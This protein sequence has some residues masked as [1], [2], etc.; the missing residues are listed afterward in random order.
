[1]LVFF[2]LINSDGIIMFFMHSRFDV[3]DNLKE[4]FLSKCS[5]S[6]TFSLNS[7]LKTIFLR[8]YILFVT[9]FIVLLVGL[10]TDIIRLLLEEST[11]LESSKEF[12]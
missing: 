1:M 6:R 10:D 5:L 12:V 9:S 11:H 8:L 3:S 4:F 7:S 2:D